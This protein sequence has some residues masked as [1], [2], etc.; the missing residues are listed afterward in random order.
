MPRCSRMNWARARVVREHATAEARVGCL[1]GGE[2]A[3]LP[4]GRHKER[5]AIRL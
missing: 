1:T 3:V 2:Q 4:A 5:R